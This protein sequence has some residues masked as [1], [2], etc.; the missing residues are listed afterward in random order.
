[1]GKLLVSESPPAKVK[2]GTFA[3]ALIAGMFLVVMGVAGYGF[4]WMRAHSARTAAPVAVT[5]AVSVPAA[6]PSPPARPVVITPIAAAQSAESA[7]PSEGT[8]DALSAAKPTVQG[9]A[10]AAATAHSSEQEPRSQRT[11]VVGKAPARPTPVLRGARPAP[12]LDTPIPVRE[13]RPTVGNDLG[14]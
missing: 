2:S 9:A 12:N 5:G 3:G 11:P 13:P 10:D 14:Y 1:M 6:A 4:V 7:N 8:S